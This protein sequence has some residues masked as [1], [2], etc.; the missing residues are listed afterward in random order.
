MAFTTSPTFRFRDALAPEPNGPELRCHGSFL[1][2][3][4]LEVH[5]LVEFLPSFPSPISEPL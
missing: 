5:R 3:R 4:N 2:S 1:C